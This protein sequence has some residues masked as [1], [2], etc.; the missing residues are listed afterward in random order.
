MQVF[1][2]ISF[3]LSKSTAKLV[4]NNTLNTLHWMVQQ[5]SKQIDEIV[6]YVKEHLEVDGLYTTTAEYETKIARLAWL[7][8]MVD[9]Q[10]GA[11]NNGKEW[12]HDQYGEKWQPRVA[13]QTKKVDAKAI[14][15]KYFTK[16]A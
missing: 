6:D 10:Q 12:F 11:L 15:S 1:D 2:T 14:V 9:E 4:D 13:G 8:D 7:T 5:N 16:A 3:N